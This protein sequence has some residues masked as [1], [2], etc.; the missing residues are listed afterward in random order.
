MTA[1]EQRGCLHLSRQSNFTAPK[2]RL[3][4]RREERDGEK[5]HTALC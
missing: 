2:T 4:E 1:K 3:N 5:T